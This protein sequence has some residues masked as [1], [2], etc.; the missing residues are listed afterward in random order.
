MTIF[1]EHPSAQGFTYVSHLVFAAGV[2]LRL[3][4][5]A[6]AFALHA[7]FPFVSIRPALD[8]EATMDFLSEQNQLVEEQGR[9]VGYGPGREAESTRL[10]IP[11][12]RSYINDQSFINRSGYGSEIDITVRWPAARV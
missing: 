12:I 7:V 1:T 2:A 10:A 3:L 8:F 9:H 5:S 6:A 4:R 11:T